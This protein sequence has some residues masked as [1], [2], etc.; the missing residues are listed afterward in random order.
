MRGANLGHPYPKPA[1]P[2][3]PSLA[4]SSETAP[5]SVEHRPFSPPSRQEWEFVT[6]GTCSEWRK[7]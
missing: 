2:G 7:P 6:L 4:Q 1:L 3:C 5:M